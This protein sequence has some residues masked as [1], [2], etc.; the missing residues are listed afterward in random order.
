MGYERY[1]QNTDPR[2]DYDVH[3]DLGRSRSGSRYQQS[4][5]DDADRDRQSGERNYGSDRYAGRG[6]S[7]GGSQDGWRGSDERGDQLRYGGGQ[8]YRGSYASDGRRFTETD[9]DDYRDR[10]FGGQR[11]T[12]NSYGER[13]DRGDQRSFGSDQYRGGYGAQQGGRS[14]RQ[15]QDDD[16][17]FLARAGD[18]VRSW[19][20]DEDA[21]RRRER[22][23]QA[24][25][26]AGQ[27]DHDYHSWRR[28]QIDSFDRDY[29]EYRQENQD[30]FHTEFNNW[31]SERQGQRDCLNKVD[32]H[33]EVVG[34]D[35]EHIGTVDK[36]RGDRIILTKNDENAGGHHHSIPSRWIDSVDD[37][38]KVRKTA[39]EAMKHWKDEERNQ[40]FG[41]NRGLGGQHGAGQDRWSTG[42]GG[43]SSFESSDQRTGGQS[44][45]SSTL[46]TSGVTSS[47]D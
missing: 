41:T 42:Q 23:Q 13:P 22:D 12:W 19:F 45:Q 46:P 34:S 17:G 36:V 31:R 21:E 30:R 33:M 2:G 43:R 10:N 7:Y 20:G 29:H 14:S 5:W 18:E 11:G 3:D 26:G 38:V 44:G 25:G 27:H 15:Q 16:R 37:K 8:P 24:G 28:N 35:G 1:L 32:E 40:D 9:D 6:R 39:A 47:A 4:D